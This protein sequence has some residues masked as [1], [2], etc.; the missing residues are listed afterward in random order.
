MP[1]SALSTFYRFRAYRA[2]PSPLSSATPAHFD[3]L[4]SEASRAHF[5]QR[6]TRIFRL[7]IRDAL[8]HDIRA[9]AYLSF[10]FDNDIIV[11]IIIFSNYAAPV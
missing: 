3:F 5:S 1:A 9:G 6:F 8:M 2:A 10:E 4:F 11:L 7:A